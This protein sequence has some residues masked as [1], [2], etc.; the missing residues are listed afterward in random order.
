MIF[1][2]KRK[3]IALL[4]SSCISAL[5]FGSDAEDFIMSCKRDA[6]TFPTSSFQEGISW[7]FDLGYCIG[8]IKGVDLAP[9]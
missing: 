6:S 1:M 4:L 9:V 3:F 5:A 7:G 8:V 2:H